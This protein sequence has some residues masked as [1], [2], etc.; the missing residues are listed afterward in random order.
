MKSK[1]LFLTLLSIALTMSVSAQKLSGNLS[2]LK[3]QKEVNVVIDFAGTTVNR[4]S[5]ESHIAFFS[6]GKNEEELAQWLKEWNQD[7]RQES[8]EKL[9]NELNQAVSSKGFSVGNY[10]NAECTI[11]VKVINIQPGAHLM[12][13]S[14]INTNVSFLKTGENSPFATVEYKNIIGKYS[15][16]VAHQRT[17]IAMAF[18]VL[19]K[20]VGATITKNLK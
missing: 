6:R 9:I 5:E 2:P 8:Y 1:T 17:R 19:G 13:N 20:K 11:V 18:G 12:T 16:Y 10:P 3:G 7:M 15:N 14:V 4:Q